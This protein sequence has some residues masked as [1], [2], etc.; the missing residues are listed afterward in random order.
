MIYLLMHLFCKSLIFQIRTSGGK[1]V[2]R[3]VD[4]DKFID[5]G[6]IQVKSQSLNCNHIHFFYIEYFLQ[7]FLYLPTKY[8]SELHNNAHVQ[9]SEFCKIR[10]GLWH[11]ILILAQVRYPH[12]SVWLMKPHLYL[13]TFLQICFICFLFRHTNEMV[14]KW[15]I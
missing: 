9:T 3:L 6:H 10:I 1:S 5:C 8:Y 15:Y 2:V 11:T 14:K 7:K 12:M 4:A 13:P